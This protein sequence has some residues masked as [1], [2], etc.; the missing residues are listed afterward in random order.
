[1][2]KPS[3]LLLFLYSNAN[4]VGSLLGLLGLGLYFLGVIHQFW[5][6]IIIGLYLIGVLA[7]PKN[8]TV[9]LQLRNQLSADDIRAGLEE[10]VHKV[11]GKL[12]QEV[13]ARVNSI[14]DSILEVLPQMMALGGG[15]YNIYLI[16]QT[17]LDYLPSALESYLN[18]PK[19][20]AN[21]Q[22][23]KDGK[24]AKQLLVEQLDLLDGEMKQV[25]QE[26][27]QNDTQKLIA[28]GR[29]LQDKFQ[30]SL[31]DT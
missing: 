17:A 19:A 28:H 5:L 13:L 14:K 31:L 27:Y 4:I 3:P 22:P 18:L 1:M 2:R 7:T 25:V 20:Y 29:F 26:V 23:V 6:P 11:Q 9:E 12:P 21:L 24:T 16:Q 30:K 10:L 8:P 15:D